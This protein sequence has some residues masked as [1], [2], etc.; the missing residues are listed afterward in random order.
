MDFTEP[1]YSANQAVL[2]KEGSGKTSLFCL[3]PQ[4]GSAG[5]NHGRPLGGGKLGEN[6]H[7]ERQSN[8]L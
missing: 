4:A 8:P 2:V 6:G 5:R 3:E 7:T 1:Y